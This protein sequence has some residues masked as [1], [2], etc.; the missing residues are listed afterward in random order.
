M[1]ENNKKEKP[2]VLDWLALGFSMIA[3]LV[4]LFK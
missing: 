1:K 2:S 4:N 3:L